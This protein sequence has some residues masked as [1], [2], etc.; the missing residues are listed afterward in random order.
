M[1][2]S[3][4][5]V[6]L[7]YPEDVQIIS[8]AMLALHARIDELAERSNKQI[9]EQAVANAAKAVWPNGMPRETPSSTPEAK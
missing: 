2:N 4:V 7:R 3:E 5:T 1:S 6:T 9:R 8:Q